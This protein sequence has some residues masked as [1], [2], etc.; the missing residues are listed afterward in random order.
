MVLFIIML[1]TDQADKQSVMKEIVRQRYV[2]ENSA[3]FWRCFI[4]REIRISKKIVLFTLRIGKHKAIVHIFVPPIAHK[5]QNLGEGL[6]FGSNRILYL[7]R[8]FGINGSCNKA[9]R[10]QFAQLVG[11]GTL[12][13]RR[14]TCLL[15]TSIRRYGFRFR[16]TY[17]AYRHIS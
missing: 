15:Y 17:G 5:L 12:G 9:V 7:W 6:P 2:Y 4:K 10:F 3:D 11:Q 16:S 13:N 14:N 1:F 8:N